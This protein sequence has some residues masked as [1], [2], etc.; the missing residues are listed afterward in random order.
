VD[1]AVHV[2]V[3]PP[4]IGIQSSEDGGGFL[5]RRRVVEIHEGPTVDLLIE[6]WE[7]LAQDYRI[8]DGR[9]EGGA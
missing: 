9:R 7:V 6:D 3:V 8:K 4:V 2:G 5:R 1:T